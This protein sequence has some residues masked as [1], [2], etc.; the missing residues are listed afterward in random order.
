VAN[1]NILQFH[2]VHQVM[3]RDM[4]IPPAQACKQ[5]RHQTGKRYQR[6][7]AKR[8]EQ[9]IEPD[10]VRFHAVQRL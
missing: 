4:R 10:H 3:Q 7:A 1:S 6:I 2:G 8:T 5:G 9:K